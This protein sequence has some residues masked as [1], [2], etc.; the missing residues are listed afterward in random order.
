MMNFMHIYH[1]IRFQ[2]EFHDEIPPFGGILTQ[3]HE[4]R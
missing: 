2:I 3:N 1:E 4:I